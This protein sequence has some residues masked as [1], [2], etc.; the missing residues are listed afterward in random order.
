ME[1][2]ILGKKY[3][4]PEPSDKNKKA[5]LSLSDNERWGH[6]ATYLQWKYPESFS[7]APKIEG[8]YYE[9]G[10]H[11]LSASAQAQVQW[12][13]D[14]PLA[15]EFLD[16]NKKRSVGE[17]LTLG[18]E[19]EAEAAIRTIMA[20]DFPFVGEGFRENYAN[21]LRE[22][23][24]GYRIFEKMYPWLA[25]GG[26]VV[27]GLGLG[28][29]YG[30]GRTALTKAPAVG[31]KAWDML[32][33]GDKWKRFLT[34]VGV[35]SASGY[36]IFGTYRHGKGEG[37]SVAGDDREGATQARLKEAFVGGED[38]P[39]WTRPYTLGPA[40]SLAAPP[41][42]SGT[43]KL[44][45]G[46]ARKITGSPS[47]HMPDYL[48]PEAKLALKDVRGAGLEQSGSLRKQ[49]LLDEIDEVTGLP[50][51]AMTRA[52]VEPDLAIAEAR[53]APS[54]VKGQEVR[55]EL[56][57]P[58]NIVG[59]E[60]GWAIREDP[61]VAAGAVAAFGKR[62]QESTGRL[63]DDLYNASLGGQR[64]AGLYLDELNTA[65]RKQY[66]IDYARAYAMKD[67]LAGGVGGRT[68]PVGSFRDVLNKNM[69]TDNPVLVEA[70]TKAQ[71]EITDRINQHALGR[72]VS[73]YG[74][75]GENLKPLPDLEVFLTGTGQKIPVYQ[76]H[77]ISKHAGESLA[78]LRADPTG[79]VKKSA[80]RIQDGWV[81]A[82]NDA[83]GKFG[84]SFP[85]AQAAFNTT[86]AYEKALVAGRN[87]D[88]YR[89]PTEVRKAYEA[90][91][92]PLGLSDADKVIALERMQKLFISGATEVARTT[93]RPSLLTSD[94][95][96]LEKLAPI[97]GRD[98]VTNLKQSLLKEGRM[99]QFSADISGIRGGPTATEEVRKGAA[100]GEQ[101]AHDVPM[102]AFS[103]SF[104][105]G[106]K[107]AQIGRKTRMLKNQAVA[108][109]IQQLLLS[110]D[111]R[112]KAIAMKK[113]YEY[114]KKAA[115]A[116]DRAIFNAMIRIGAT[117]ETQ[118]IPE[119]V[120]GLI[121]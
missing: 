10:T 72:D 121:N 28:G 116:E 78:A 75:K 105:A 31:K 74:I 99:T 101:A 51:P 29:V 27:G 44:L 50:I 70:W 48:S 14:N 22:I 85:K 95:T 66:D 90:L 33:K 56:E 93:M 3:E 30:V 81:G 117:P 18:H 1:L 46:Y 38:E 24:A 114:A 39:W 59:K 106:R 69:E 52:S 77:L 89:T 60:A 96:A 64:E 71:K 79:A 2:T 7:K 112:A 35:G 25:L 62:A 102:F 91:K 110:T 36:G 83:I 21:K 120:T 118:N 32:S 5:W 68:P 119:Q 34:T 42:I 17:G 49:G 97:L 76:A 53:T 84:K 15:A 13:A 26:E 87:L 11:E 103:P 55:G 63:V 40:V 20:G 65:L 92:A 109:E 98:G 54:L 16:V 23:D 41:L 107:A 47:Q 45:G 88:A 6:I 58:L 9:P 108:S 111:P 94:I 19:G 57:V 61:G 113:I 12:R 37:G 104:W 4:V 115:T 67:M 8:S 82:W 80:L 86:D 73:I 100:I 43:A